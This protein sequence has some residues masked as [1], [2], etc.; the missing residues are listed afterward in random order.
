MELASWHPP[1]G[2]KNL[3]VAPRFLENLWI[4]GKKENITMSVILLL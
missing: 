3:K 4:Y 1:Y 2:A